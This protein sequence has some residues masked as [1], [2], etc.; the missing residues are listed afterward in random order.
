LAKWRLQRSADE[1]WRLNFSHIR[2][3]K[4]KDKSSPLAM[5]S[6]G[7]GTQT[8]GKAMLSLQRLSIMRKERGEKKL[9]GR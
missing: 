9:A 2:Q 3:T 7:T 6:S 4:I 1:T 5:H 8:I